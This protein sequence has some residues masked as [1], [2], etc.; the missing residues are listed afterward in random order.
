MKKIKLF[1]MLGTALLV[2]GCANDI[3][4]TQGGTEEQPA[5][6]ALTVV[7]D[8]TSTGRKTTNY[9]LTRVPPLYPIW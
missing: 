3:D 2:A 4:N 9:G 8:S 1:A 5:Q 6:R 7:R